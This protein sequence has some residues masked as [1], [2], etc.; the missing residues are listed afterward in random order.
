MSISIKLQEHLAKDAICEVFSDDA[1]PL[2]DRLFE[3]SWLNMY[4]YITA[5]DGSYTSIVFP[6][7]DYTDIANEMSEDELMEEQVY[8]CEEY[9]PY[10]MKDALELGWHRAY[11]TIGFALNA[12][13]TLEDL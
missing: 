8:M 11:H 3:G 5:D 6:D 9:E 12:G 10:T 2:V 1:S 4:E 7:P 13:I